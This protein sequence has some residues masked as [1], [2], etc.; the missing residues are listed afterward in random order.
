VQSDEDGL[1][2]VVYDP[3]GDFTSKA[4]PRFWP[5]AKDDRWLDNNSRVWRY[6]E[7]DLGGK[8]VMR[9]ITPEALGLKMLSAGRFLKAN[10]ATELYYRRDDET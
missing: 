1:V 2:Y 6:M 9:F 4:N 3:F 5:P 8:K 7:V 10:E